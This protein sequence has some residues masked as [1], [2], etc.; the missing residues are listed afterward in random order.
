MRCSILEDRVAVWNVKN[1]NL[2]LSALAA[3]LLVE[4]KKLHWKQLRLIRHNE[5]NDFEGPGEPI[6]GGA[7]AIMGNLTGI[8]TGIGSV[9]FKMAK[10]GRRRTKHE[11]KKRRRSEEASRKSMKTRKKIN[12]QTNGALTSGHANDKPVD[13]EQTNGHTDGK[14]KLISGNNQTIPQNN[15]QFQGKESQ[16]RLNDSAEDISDSKAPARGAE[17]TT[18]RSEVAKK[19][20]EGEPFS[21]NKNAN[22]EADQNNEDDDN[23]SEMS[24]DPEG[25][26]AEEMAR[27]AGEGLSG[28]AE[29]FARMPMDLSLAIAQGFHNA[30]RLY[31]D[32]TVR[33]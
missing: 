5:W 18:S 30:P 11:E 2:R 12:E 14:G 32:E 1:T 15:D 24:D 4:K 20:S 28:T 33:R 27:D 31:G 19:T 17:K 10:T 9:P 13:E 6:T 23:E 29:A 22:K 25:N 7:T 3:E 8:A 26:M 21:Q 16:T